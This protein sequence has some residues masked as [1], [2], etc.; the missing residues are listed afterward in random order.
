[1]VSVPLLRAALAAFMSLAVFALAAGAAP[2]NDFFAGGPSAS[3]PGLRA[4]EIVGEVE[5]PGVVDLSALPRH[6]VEV[7][8]SDLVDGKMSFTGAYRYEGVSLFDLL[9]D[10]KVKKTHGDGF[11][12]D[13]DLLVAVEGER[14][15]RAV[16]SWGEIFYAAIP[17]RILVADRVLSVVPMK[18]GEPFP[19]PVFAR[20]VCADDLV[21]ARFVDRPR[22]IT[23]FSAPV[24]LEQR[25][26]SSDP[27]PFFTFTAGNAPGGKR[28]DRI[29]R[30]IGSKR[31]SAAFYGHGMGFH[32]FMEFRGFPFSEVLADHLPAD[33]GSLGKAYLVVCA[34]DGYRA[35]LSLS[36]LV[37]RCD[38]REFALRDL[39]PG[40]PGGRF[41][42]YPPSDFF[43]D[44]AVKALESVRVFRLQ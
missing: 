19:L 24:S 1:M 3:L 5:S 33:R 44:R 2:S 35:A 7:R 27:A 29:P 22:R 41:A 12:P 10:R 31:I 38:G 39:G 6:T 34:R 26:G 25:K 40:A 18:T 15:E 42:L 17:H 16:V 8:E 4:I 14:G 30:G 20:L 43:V 28:F 23:V 37:N 9:R 36:E 11:K 21:A 13:V 32:G